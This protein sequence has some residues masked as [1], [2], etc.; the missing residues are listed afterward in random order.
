M[1]P[2]CGGTAQ[3]CRTWPEQNQAKP[4]LYIPLHAPHHCRSACEGTHAGA[5]QRCPLGTSQW[6]DLGGVT[7]SVQETTPAWMGRKVSRV[8]LHPS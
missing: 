5:M 6:S 4:G 7:S 2:H 1:R 8:A 3:T